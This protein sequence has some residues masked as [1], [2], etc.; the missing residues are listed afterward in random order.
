MKRVIFFLA[1]LFTTYVNG[2]P[3]YHLY[4]ADQHVG[5]LVGSA[6]VHVGVHINV[7]IA[8]ILSQIH[9]SKNV[10]FEWDGNT[11]SI[12]VQAGIFKVSTRQSTKELILKNGLKCSGEQMQIVS[13]AANINSQVLFELIPAAFIWLGIKPVE[14]P[15]A[16]PEVKN[17]TSLDQLLIF[18][19]IKNKKQVFNMDSWEKIADKLAMLSDSEMLTAIEISCERLYKNRFFEQKENLIFKDEMAQYFVKGDDNAL[20]NETIKGLK[21]VNWPQPLLDIIFKAREEQFSEK[22]VGIISEL[23][24]IDKPTFI[25]GA[26]HT[27]STYLKS[28]LLRNGIEMKKTN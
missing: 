22:I 18:E 23:E 13:K 10:Y 8:R 27:S 28:Y 14:I 20:R 4:K 24:G 6:H 21:L 5:T 26:A 1:F 7:A 3:I 15:S 19:S 2:Q 12:L 11:P 16:G 9:S 17:S 25:L